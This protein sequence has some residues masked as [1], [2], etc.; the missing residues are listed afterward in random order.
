MNT[1]FNENGIEGVDYI[2]CKECN[3][4]MTRLQWTHFKKCKSNITYNEYKLKY[5]NAP[6][7]CENTKKYCAITNNMLIQK[8]GEVE[9]NIR[10][11]LYCLL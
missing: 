1:K 2:C 6:L 7:I 10:W 9:G 5:P 3:K 11:K 4:K 8:Y